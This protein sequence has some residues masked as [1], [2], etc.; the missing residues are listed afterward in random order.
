MSNLNVI[1]KPQKILSVQPAS[2]T[3]SRNNFLNVPFA[4]HTDQRIREFDKFK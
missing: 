1:D 2:S 3:L 4:S